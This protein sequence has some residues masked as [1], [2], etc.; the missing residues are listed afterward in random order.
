MS[1]N[2]TP[3]PDG[4]A[5]GAR[6]IAAMR[7][8]ALA[9]AAILCALP[10]V[11]FSVRQFVETRHYLDD[12][13]SVIGRVLQ[14]LRAQQLLELDRPQRLV[15]LL[16]SAAG[17][18]MNF[19]ISD[20]SG[21]I[22]QHEADMR[23]P[24]VTVNHQIALDD[25][26]VLD[27]RMSASVAPR[28]PVM[29]AA[30]AVSLAA[31]GLMYIFVTRHIYQR[32]LELDA[33]E[34]RRRQDLQIIENLGSD[35]LW[36]TDADLNLT[37]ISANSGS[38]HELPLGVDLP[39]WSSPD[40]SPDMSWS[41]IELAMMERKPVAWRARHSR[42]DGI[43]YVEFK[44]VPTY[45]N[46]IFEG[47]FGIISDI[48]YI[49]EREKAL[50]EER[51][52]LSA[53]ADRNAQ[54]LITARVE[55]ESANKAKS[56]FLA[57][58]S[59]EMR[60][61]LN[62]IM[63]LG[64]LL[65]K[66]KLD[67]KQREYVDTVMNSSEMLLSLIN[68]ILDLGKV[69]SGKAELDLA[70]VS[71]ADIIHEAIEMIRPRALAR[72][73]ELI[74]ELDPQLLYGTVISDR[75]RLTQVLLNY[76]SNAVKFTETG[77]IVVKARIINEAV[78]MD[79]HRQLID[80]SVEDS[81]IGMTADQ[82]SR[83]FKAFTQVDDNLAR[84]H[85]GTGLG[86]SIVKGIAKLMHGEVAVL[87]RPGKGSTFSFRVPL[88]RVVGQA[89]AD[90]PVQPSADLRIL[91][92]DPNVRTIAAADASLAGLGIRFMGE[93]SL[94]AACKILL[95]AETA[96]EPMHAVLMACQLGEITGGQAAAVIAGLK[97]PSRPRIF[98]MPSRSVDE[99][100]LDRRPIDCE[101]LPKPV[102]YR[103]LLAELTQSVPGMS[104]AR[105]DVLEPGS[106]PPVV[107][108]PLKGR[109]AMLVD[110][111]RVSLLLM[112]ELL[113]GC[114]ATCSKFSG[115]PEAIDSLRAG[116][117]CDFALINMQLPDMGGPAL[118]AQLKQLRG[119]KDMQV[120][121][122]TEY[123]LQDE[124]VLVEQAAVCGV[125]AKPLSLKSLLALLEPVESRDA[126]RQ[127][128]EEIADADKIT[129][130]M[131]GLLRT[132]D[133]AAQDFASE[134]SE[135]LRQRLD[136]DAPAFF[137]AVGM[138]D[139]ERALSVLARRSSDSRPRSY[140]VATA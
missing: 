138:Y 2:T 52:L 13:V 86:L 28:I 136:N 18:T 85:E 22:V 112:E 42:E 130:R 88:N 131:V 102:N 108:G 4:A 127:Q 76:L 57:T 137:S 98:C 72:Q 8:F 35:W 89:N 113:R 96:G 120:V 23:S 78:D 61:P 91:M 24:L 134:H 139:F 119:A 128:S 81:G 77:H 5:N 67:F 74:V 66:S 9:L 30:W 31:F 101:L 43:V 71:V 50:R 49:L 75:K 11:V 46:G 110:Q 79:D 6:Y 17:N 107:G 41:R 124:S 7:L 58:M 94:Q 15:E 32:W 115:A 38:K 3:G 25:T 121:L 70:E 123:A 65:A 83:L 12:N 39:V 114:G 140:T 118:A 16:Q 60:T 19:E 33:L 37:F 63:G 93:T 34:V 132:G 21:R 36:R 87:S 10:V 55:A 133:L 80:I 135:L 62:A 48:S 51:E 26:T 104:S 56:Q 29:I 45:R 47:Y 73:L 1:V 95:A 84:R 97:L 40:L 68:D 106:R 14:S 125:L 82:Q 90:M 64:S 59:H 69:E 53:L 111:D 92:I 20:A 116:A 27:V 122:T 100:P 99:I 109:H 126:S 54:E 103:K 117:A 44:G 129:N 105:A